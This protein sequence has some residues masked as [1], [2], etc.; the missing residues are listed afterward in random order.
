M[1]GL[2]DVEHRLD[3]RVEAL[4]VQGLV[5][6]PLG[7]PQRERVH[8]R[9]VGGQRPGGWAKLVEGDN[10]VHHAG[11][12]RLLRGEVPAGEQDLLGLARAQFPGVPVVLDAAD[13][14][15]DDRVGEAGVVGRDDQVARPAQQ[16]P[17]GDARALDGGDRRL[18]HVA[19]AQRVL[20]EPAGL[21]GVDPGQGPLRGLAR[22]WL[23][24]AIRLADGLDV[25]AG[26]EVLP[27]GLQDDH[28]HVVVAGGA[29]PGR[30]E[31]VEQLQRLGVSRLRAVQRDRGDPVAGF[32]ADELAPGFARHG[33]VW[34]DRAHFA[35]C[36]LSSS[37]MLAET[38]RWTAD[39]SSG[40]ISSIQD[41][42][43]SRPSACG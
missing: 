39:G 37:Y 38:I 18:G 9:D 34:H 35:G 16:Q 17:A 6:R 33:I 14:H 3:G 11:P 1:A 40:G 30:V 24:V 36:R 21:D 42:G 23:T 15:V 8:L 4:H 25:V 27:V 10:A 2:V 22:A 19:P 32:V 43:S 13:A 26:G 41:N 20:K 7:L 28:P 5:D 29:L 31:L 12:L